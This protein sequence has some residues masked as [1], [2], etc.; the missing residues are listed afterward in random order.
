MSL[1]GSFVKPFH[2]KKF[3]QCTANF[4]NNKVTNESIDFQADM[5][6]YPILLDTYSVSFNNWKLSYDLGGDVLQAFKTL[7]ITLKIKN[8]QA[9]NG[10]PIE[11]LNACSK[12][13]K[14]YDWFAFRND[15]YDYNQKIDCICWNQYDTAKEYN[16]VEYTFN[17]TWVSDLSDNGGGTE[18]SYH[19][20]N[21]QG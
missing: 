11:N 5:I 3:K 2:F 16:G 15:N 21:N 4:E 10:W 17:N 19:F 12:L 7:N 6:A 14:A 1:S 9:Q 8:I 13:C 20:Y 18:E